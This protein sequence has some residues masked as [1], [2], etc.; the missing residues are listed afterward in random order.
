M[1]KCIFLDRDGVI[2]IERGSYTWRLE[3][4]EIV[5][6]VVDSLQELKK[7][8]FLLVVVTN[9]S[10]ISKGLFTKKDMESCHN[11]MMEKT[12]YLINDIYYATSNPEFSE[13]LLRKPDSL[14]FEKAIAKFNIDPKKSW[15]MGDSDRDLAPAK[16]LG[17]RTIFIS[18]KRDSG[19]SDHM[20]ANLREATDI[21]NQNL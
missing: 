8:G 3:D 9:Q 10:G 16:K 4:F 6:G 21:I 11:L 17:I 1:N 5:P 13:S 14:M 2:N 12:N 20:A 19:K 15:M 7:K 18:K